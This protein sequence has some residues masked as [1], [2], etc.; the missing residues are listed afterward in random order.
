[1]RI[2][3]TGGAGAIGRY[4]CDELIAAENNVICV[5]VH[6]PDRKMPYKTVDLLSLDAAT[7][8]LGDVDCIAHLAAIPDPFQGDSQER[9]MS[10][11]TTLSYNVFEAARLNGVPRVIYGCSESS[12]GLGIHHV[13]LRPEYVP[14]DE[15]HPLR[16]HETYSLS[17]YFGDRIGV[18]YAEAFG[19]EVISMRYVWVWTHRVAKEAARIVERA[20]LGTDLDQLDPKDWLGGHIAVRDVAR[21]FRDASDYQFTEQGSTFE[22]FFLSARDTFNTVPT[23]DPLTR[24]FGSCPTIRDEAY[25]KSNPRASLYDIRKAKR[26]LQWAPLHR[27]EDFESWEL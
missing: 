20:R 18:N 25:F 5:D 13:R 17:K 12:T 16:P 9:V 2:A 15:D 3:V 23:L 26:L 10:V 6:K 27:W 22:S 19:M 11:N 8:A 7:S 1:V 24:A 21:A 14:I 4:V